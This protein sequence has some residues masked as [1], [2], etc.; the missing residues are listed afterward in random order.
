MR[1][2]FALPLLLTVAAA[3][4]QPAPP[5]TEASTSATPITLEQA[6][7]DPD[8][9]GPAIDAAWWSWD[10]KRAIFP[11]KRTGSN[12]RDLYTVAV[13]GG[14]MAKVA[15]A[16]RTRLDAGNPAF[17]RAR[18]HEVY[19]RN[20][21]VFLRDLSTGALSQLSRSAEQEAEPRFSADQ[22]AVLWRVDNTWYRYRLSD[23]L[24]ETAA[25]PKAEKNP[26]APPDKPD[27]MRD[28]QLRLIDTLRR[29]KQQRDAQREQDREL[30]QADPTRAAAPIYL[31]DDIHIDG[32]SL[33]PDGRWLLVVTSPKSA[34]AGRVGKL[35]KYVTES[36]YE[37][38]EDE[39]TRVGRNSPVGESLELVDLADG[40]VSGLKLDALPGIDVDPLAALR[41]AAGKDPLKG[42]RPVRIQ[43]ES[44][45]GGSALH[46]SDDGRGLALM[47]RAIDNKDR[48]IATVDF[49]GKALRSVHRLTDP[50]WINWSFND[51]GWMPGADGSRDNRLWLLSEQ[52]GYS[53][54]Y[55]VVPG[56]AAKQH[57]RGEWEVSQPVVSADGR[58]VWF[59]CNRKSPGDYE[60]CALD[61]ANDSV[62]ELTALHGV[63][64]FTPSPDQSR[65][66]VRYSASYLPAQLAVVPANGGEA[67]TLTDTRTPEF[68]ARQWIQPEFVQVP[69]SHGAKPIRAK[70]YRPAQ[71]EPGKKY[72]LV[73]FVHGA[74]YTQN[75]YARYPYYFR[76]QMFHNLLVQQGYLVLDMDY[77]GS[78]GYGRDW[79][80]AIYQHMGH[81]ELEDYID[82]VD[83]LV[84]KQQ[85]DRDRVGIYGGSYGGFMTL[86]A[87]FR[88][89][90]VFKAGAALRP[91]S[92]WSTYNHEYTSNILNTPDIDPEAYR[93]SSPIE[94]AD[95]LRGALL[96]AQ[97]MMDNNV[98]FQDSV[99]LAQRLI[100]L[101]KP[102]WS[103]APYPL[104]RHNF[105]QPDAWLDEYRRIDLLFERVLK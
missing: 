36:G 62:R 105:V 2:V 40:S 92:D 84:A 95:G 51:F 58:R 24:L 47:V 12:L 91:V 18:R 17:D 76:E 41:K 46:W 44:D 85:G 50:A 6:M 81:P 68:K 45:D 102:D 63:E 101:K 23:H 1:P 93:T 60:V 19:V 15:D 42:Q 27:A 3:T 89:P 98:F 87:M 78:A 29:Q 54:F 56:G 48:W 59:V 97:G 26:A 39:R 16:E 37:E 57:T 66:L 30:R 82:G 9:I 14:A 65:L 49:A 70:F 96:I 99:R 7:A 88:A 94:Y 55:T 34:D 83:W 64:D 80:D 52:T 22:S 38:F 75:V 20:G 10:G 25:L 103:I 73:L 5:V 13:A 4:A 71:L 72:P 35:P 74:G 53:H 100:E 86:M 90:D 21:D 77:R 43:T 33:S 11:L 28:M 31:G 104:E 61:L 79:R 67:R 8:W 32:T 69:S